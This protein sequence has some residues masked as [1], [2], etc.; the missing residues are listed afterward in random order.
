M[1]HCTD[2]IGRGL[3][4]TVFYRTGFDEN[5]NMERKLAMTTP[6]LFQPLRVAGLTLK[7]RL[8]AAPTSLAELGPGEHYSKENLD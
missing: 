6:H 1:L 7:N 8:L 4:Y 5:R 2:A 3:W